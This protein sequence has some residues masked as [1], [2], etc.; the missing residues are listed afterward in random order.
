[1][2]TKLLILRAVPAALLAIA[3]PLA[4]Q[5]PGTLL[6]S[7]PMVGAPAGAQ[8]WRIRYTSLNDRNVREEVTGVVIAPVGPAPRAGRPVL[9]W[10]HGTWGVVSK[11]TPASP[12]DFFRVTP[13]V[14]D[15]VRRG[16]TIIAT[17]YAGMGTPQ[18][19]PYL[20][21][22][23]AAHSVLDSIRAARALPEAG[24]GNRFAV[25]GESQGGHAALFTGEY[26]KSY[27]PEL[28]LVGVAAAAPP[29]DLV[30]NLTGGSDPSVRA[31]LTAFTAHSW[32]E[33]F[34][35]KLSTLGR[36][37]TQRLIGRLAQNCIS[38]DK[39][40]KLG[41]IIG[42]S[43]LRR[44]L[45]GVDLGR[46]QPWARLARDNSAGQRPPG[47]PV[48]IAQNSKDSI[49][50]PEVTRTF[51]RKLCAKRAKVRYITLTTKGGH[52]TS[53]ADSATMTLDW[54]D[55]RFAG[56]PAPNDCGRI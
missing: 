11:C 40:P 2:P 24:V 34:G 54:I 7:E 15:A 47:G 4:A 41:T 50:S 21:G 37:A 46:I 8:A 52:P 1:M 22:A 32:S 53:G 19:H 25:W 45:K 30:A 5:A 27:A 55:G 9:A 28:E 42:I 13:G 48:L 33:H 39:S 36:P 23:S 18:P 35:A 38:L 31:F 14:S 10:A 29:T 6:S 51:A 3:I 56:Q 16:Y 44:D 43:I 26:A 12:A 20:V 17:D 49:V